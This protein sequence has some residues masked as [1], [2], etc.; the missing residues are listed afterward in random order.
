MQMN[1]SDLANYIRSTCKGDYSIGLHGINAE[2]MNTLIH[3]N[4]QD[5]I[6]TIMKDGL[7]IFHNRTINGT[8]RFFGR[9]DKEEDRTNVDKEL[10]NY[11][12]GDGTDYIVVAIPSTLR[13]EDGRELFLGATNLDSKYMGYMGSTG[14]ETTTILDAVI[15]DQYYIR[16]EY[17]LGRFITLENG[18]I[19]YIPNEKHISYRNGIVDNEY[20]NEIENR[21]RYLLMFTGVDMSLLEN[22]DDSN[23]LKIQELINILEGV[24]YS[25]KRDAFSAYCNQ[26]FICETLKQL[27][28]EKKKRKNK[29]EE[30]LDIPFKPSYDSNNEQRIIVN[31]KRG[32]YYHIPDTYYVTFEYPNVIQGRYMLDV[33]NDLLKEYGSHSDSHVISPYLVDK[34][35]QF[36]TGW[37]PYGVGGTNIPYD[38]LS[39]FIRR[40]VEEDKCIVKCGEYTMSDV[41]SHETLDNMISS[42]KGHYS[43]QI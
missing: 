36:M 18:L 23:E 10:G 8:V 6:D 35:G 11:Q 38:L 14:S 4:L 1:R 27:L 29:T 21:V 32:D 2:R 31:L 3:M 12:Y 26:A 42:L 13:S 33:F 40:F 5:G 15:M 22:I 34:N 25:R 28:A 20:F 9:I 39:K 19:E 30:E 41:F 37:N 43:R 24:I 17:I 7:R 16:P